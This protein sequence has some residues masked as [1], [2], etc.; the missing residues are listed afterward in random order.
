MDEK[1]PFLDAYKKKL[2]DQPANTEDTQVPVAEAG[3][4]PGSA[5][6]FEEQ[7]TFAAPREI[8]LAGNSRRSPRTKVVSLI[9]FAGILVLVAVLLIW[10]FSRGT[11]VIDLTDWALTDAQLWAG[12]NRINLQVKEEYSDSF[13]EGKI[14]S[15]S[16]QPGDKIKKN[17]FLQ[18]TVSRGHDP[19][20]T[21][22]LPDLLKMTMGEVEAWAADNYM[23]K[24]RITSEY[25]DSVVSGR[26]IRYEI[27]DDTVVDKVK[28]STPIYVIVSKGSE[29]Q[30][31]EPI[32]LPDFRELSI[33]QSQQ[34]AKDN[35]L[36]LKINEAYDDFAPSGTIIDQST[37]PE[38][39]VEPGTI[40]TL[41]VSRGRKIL[42]PDFSAYTKDQAAAAASE[43]GIPIS[44]RE[45]YSSADT[46]R[47]LSQSLTSG[48]VYMTGDIL[49]LVYSLGNKIVLS[50]YV[51]QP[52]VSIEA[53]AQ[54]LNEQGAAIRISVTQTQNN[55]PRDTIIYQDK[56]NIVIGTSATIHVTVSL[57]RKVSVPD[58]VAVEGSEYG[59]AV[60]RDIATAACEAVGLIPVYVP[61]KKSGRLPGEIWYQSLEPGKEVYEGTPVTLKYNPSDVAVTLPDFRGK[62]EA[63]IIAEGYRKKLTITFVQAD[64]PVAGFADQVVEQSIRAGE[65]VAAGT[66][67]TL[68]ISPP[69]PPVETDPTDSTSTDPSE[70]DQ[71]G[72]TSSEA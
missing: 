14:I 17:G 62:T 60:T 7:P 40:I 65:T 19:D 52:R 24:V 55:A 2:G 67:I 37:D 56:A 9:I 51:G 49:E 20:V 36:T 35:N 29:P 21:L 5:L 11:T 47:F 23:T 3:E 48:S 44:V 59:I 46:G 42:I 25:S 4:K 12:D 26:V 38:E 27:N 33:A 10:L 31:A 6:H 68:T 32:V 30:T 70:S 18:I 45:R 22:E 8:A 28:R 66:S 39:E 54:E 1:N 50:S 72:S 69:E 34:F 61:E 63:A 13:E 16:P 53:W 58:L 41:T 64:L 71:T 57:G 15:Q 43:L